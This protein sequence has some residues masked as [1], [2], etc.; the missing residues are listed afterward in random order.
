MNC[1]ECASE[2]TVLVVQN[3]ESV[4]DETTLLDEFADFVGCYDCHTM[5]DLRSEAEKPDESEWF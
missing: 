2:E 1:P 5:T 3:P 4:A